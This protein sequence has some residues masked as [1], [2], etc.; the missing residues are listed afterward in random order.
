MAEVELKEVH[1]VD[2]NI[3]KWW[4]PFHYVERFFVENVIKRTIAYI[5][6]HT[7]SGYMPISATEDGALV[8][9]PTGTGAQDHIAAQVACGNA[10]TDVINSANVCILADIWVYGTD[11]EF[12]VSLDGVVYSS[13][14]IKVR[15]GEKFTLNRR[16]RRIQAKSNDP[17]YNTTIH[18]IA[19]TV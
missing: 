4:S 16:F 2:P 17:N 10:F 18:A 9:A 13:T 6:G 3:R 19:Y 11:A 8:V 15:V 12:Q 5:V 7:S 1:D 14:T